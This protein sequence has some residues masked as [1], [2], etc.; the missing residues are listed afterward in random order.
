V[1]SGSLTFARPE[2]AEISRLK[3]DPLPQSWDDGVYKTSGYSKMGI[4]E[5]LV[6]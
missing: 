5:N 6:H 3:Y 2:I 1:P 4:S